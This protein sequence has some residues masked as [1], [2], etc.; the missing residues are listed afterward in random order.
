MN[1]HEIIIECLKRDIP[2]SLDYDIENNQMC[3]IVSGF[4]KSGQVKLEDSE[5]TVKVTARYNQTTTIENFEDLA[6]IAKSWYDSYKQNGYSIDI[7]WLNVFLEY[8]WVKKVV[9]TNI[10]YK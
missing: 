10:S 7:Y 6:Y 9:T 8:E 1:A 2:V 5:G 4:A 3:Y